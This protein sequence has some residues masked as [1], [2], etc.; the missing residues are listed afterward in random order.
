MLEDNPRARNFYERA[1]WEPDG[2]RKLDRFL[3]TEVSELRYRKR[4]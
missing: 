3:E 2:G 1:G 4:L